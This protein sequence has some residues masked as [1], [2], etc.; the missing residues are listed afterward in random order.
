MSIKLS[1]SAVST[2][3]SCGEKYRLERIEK[4]PM[5]LANSPLWFGSSIDRASEVIF[6]DK[7]NDLAQYQEYDRNKMLDVF[8]HALTYINFNDKMIDTRFNDKV[9]YSKND[10]DIRL[11]DK[12][13]INNI[14]I[15]SKEL[16][17]E[18]LTRDD[19]A[20]F[21]EFCQGVKS[22][23]DLEDQLLYNY[24]GHHCLLRKGILLLDALKDWSDKKLKEVISIQRYFRIVDHEGNAYSGLLDLEAILN[25][26]DRR[27]VLD[28][29]TASNAKAQYPDN[30]IDSSMQLAGYAEV[31]SK[32][33]GYI[34]LDKNIRV[35]EPRV[36]LREVYGEVSEELIEKTF[37]KIEFV[38]ENVKAGIFEKNPDSCFQWGKCQHYTRCFGNRNKK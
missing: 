10:L 24:I 13:D 22:G 9:R 8:V 27:W 11:L 5:E 25:D 2:Y 20:E 26:D 33:A 21:V 3:L 12:E 19:L 15:R 6:S 37:D 36:H 28:L 7:I 38:L 34:V 35:R 29:K 17:F 30:I 23:L 32:N 14:I 1:Y 4:I 31:S 16:G 18:E